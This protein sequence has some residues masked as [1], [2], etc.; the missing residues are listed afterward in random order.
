M[1]PGRGAARLGPRLARLIRGTVPRHTGG[2]THGP[3]EIEHIEY[4]ALSAAGA[5]TARAR[6][7]ARLRTGPR[8]LPQSFR[9]E[10][11]GLDRI[12]AALELPAPR[13][14]RPGSRLPVCAHLDTALAVET[15]KDSL[16]TLIETFR[17]IEP[18]LE[19]QRRV[20]FD[21]TASSNFLDGHANAM[22]LAQLPAHT[23][24]IL[25]WRWLGAG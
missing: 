11:S 8:A 5:T 21:E 14:A 3:Q 7:S 23:G 17:A 20:S 13:Q 10:K 15:G 18:S 4:H 2:T 25:P 9:F 1:A 12:A 16:R 22:I 24:E 6:R 19:W